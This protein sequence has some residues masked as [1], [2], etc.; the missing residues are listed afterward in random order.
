MLLTQM[1]RQVWG[2]LLLLGLACPSTVPAAE[3]ET[4]LAAAKAA[5]QAYQFFDGLNGDETHE[6]LLEAIHMAVED[7]QEAMAS[8]MISEVESCAD[9]L[10]IDFDNFLLY[11]PD[12]QQ[13]FARDYLHCLTRAVRLMDEPVTSPEGVDRLGRAFNIVAGLTL[14]VHEYLDFS[15]DGVHD[16]FVEGNNKILTKLRPTCSTQE[17]EPGTPERW[18]ICRAY[19]GD[20]ADG[21]VFLGSSTFEDDQ[22]RLEDEA[23]RNISYLI[24]KAMLEVDALQPVPLPGPGN[25]C[26]IGLACCELG[27]GG[28]SLC[29]PASRG[30]P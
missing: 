6:R 11:S 24:A 23:A 1:K 10:V 16:L 15:T 30:C 5:Y 29:V 25:G 7:I 8:I 21:H 3:I 26:P 28:C 13:A 2:L 12:T 9:A 14:F 22:E 27:P 17:I 20:S 4:A 19:N 18:M